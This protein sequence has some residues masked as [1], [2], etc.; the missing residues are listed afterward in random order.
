MVKEIGGYIE[1]DSYNLPM[2]H[3]NAIGLNCARNAADY[4]IKS[5]NIKKL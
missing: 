5:K 1:L 3:E 4:L 2:L